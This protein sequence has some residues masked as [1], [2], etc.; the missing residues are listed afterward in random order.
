MRNSIFLDKLYILIGLQ[1]LLIFGPVF[2]LKTRRIGGCQIRS[3]YC[4]AACLEVG[5]YV[6]LLNNSSSTRRDPV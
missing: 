2:P 5:K 4:V 1:A 3:S 6:E